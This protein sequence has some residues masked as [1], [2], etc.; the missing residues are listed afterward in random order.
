MNIRRMFDVLVLGGFA[1]TG[2]GGSNAKQEPNSSGSAGAGGSAGSGGAA[3]GVGGG[4]GSVGQPCKLDSE[5]GAGTFCNVGYTFGATTCVPL[6]AHGICENHTHC[7]SGRCAQ[8]CIDPNRCQESPPPSTASW[9]CV[10]KSD[11]CDAGS[12]CL[13]G[14]CFVLRA[15]GGECGED[16]QCV[17]G[18]CTFGRCGTSTIC[19]STGT[20][21]KYDLECCPGLV[22][23]N[24]EGRGCN[25]VVATPA[26]VSPADAGHACCRGF[27]CKSKKCNQTSWLCD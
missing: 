17:T 16:N 25:D 7:Q 11:C 1:L 5:C 18:H 4:A 13:N 14:R 8:V 20:V 15:D 27:D 10:D 2:C 19:A 24:A 6:L 3:A 12:R 26:C 21:C 22:C 9:T 23:H